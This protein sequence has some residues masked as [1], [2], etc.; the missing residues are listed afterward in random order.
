MSQ[1]NVYADESCHVGAH[2]TYMI[3]GAIWCEKD[4]LDGLNEKIKLIKMRHGI[5]SHREIKWTKVSSAKLDYY[6]ELADFFVAEPSLKFRAVVISKEGLDH[7]RFGQTEDDF[8]YK[9]MFVM[10]KNIAQ[11]TQEEELKIF[12]DYKD[13]WSNGRAVKLADYLQHTAALQGSYKAQPIRSYESAALQLADFLIGAVAYKCRGLAT[14][15]AKTELVEYIENV[16][17]QDISRKTPFGIDKFNLFFWEPR[18]ADETSLA[19]Q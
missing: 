17:G 13:T 16:V 7:Q 12:L 19:S 8:Y 4:K 11:K 1:V 3:L 5:S 18:V 9:M 15:E 10:L 6:K 2:S 14:S